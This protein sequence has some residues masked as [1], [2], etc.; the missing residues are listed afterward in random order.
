[1][2]WKRIEGIARYL[3]TDSTLY[4]WCSG[5][6]GWGDLWRNL[7]LR[8]EQ[9][10][11]GAW[12]AS[13]DIWEARTVWRAVHGFARDRHVHIIGFSRGAAVAVALAL[14]LPPDITYSL[15][16]YAPKRAANRR[17]LSKLRHIEAHAQKGDVIPFL[18]PWFAQV[19]LKW[20]GPLMWPWEAHKAM[21]KAAVKRRHEI[22]KRNGA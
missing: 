16:L 6:D 18:P 22:G 19:Q 4:L 15:E 20:R 12:V 10:F 5:S 1:M 11:P 17:A 7:D 2:R 14:W 21:A 8:A 3:T 13:A 9:V